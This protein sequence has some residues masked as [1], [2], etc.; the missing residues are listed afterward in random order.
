MRHILRFQSEQQFQSFFS[1]L[2]GA[3]M[4]NFMAVDGSNGDSGFDGIDGQTAYQA[5]FPEQHNRT[6]KKFITKIDEDV[7]KVLNNKLGIRVKRWVFVIPE[8]LRINVICHLI[9]QS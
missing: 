1:Q 7:K 6:D 3:E 4:P 8:D 5:Y 2:A 9:K